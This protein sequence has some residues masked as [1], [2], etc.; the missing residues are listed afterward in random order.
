M[1]NKVC[2]YWLIHIKLPIV[3]LLGTLRSSVKYIE[4][5]KYVIYL[6]DLAN[7]AIVNSLIGAQW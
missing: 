1:Q 2:M 3:S 6:G 5:Y 4:Y 7:Y